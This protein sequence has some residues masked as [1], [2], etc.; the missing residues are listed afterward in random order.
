MKAVFQ[1]PAGGRHSGGLGENHRIIGVI[2]IALEYTENAALKTGH[3]YK[4]RH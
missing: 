2:N 1:L 3:I 4:I